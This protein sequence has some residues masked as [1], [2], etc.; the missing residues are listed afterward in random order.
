[1]VNK[2]HKDPSA[3]ADHDKLPQ[4]KITHSN[5]SLQYGKW[6]NLELVDD[7]KTDGNENAELDSQLL[8]A[9][10]LGMK[11]SLTEVNWSTHAESRTCEHVD[12]N[13]PQKEC[14]TGCITNDW[15]EPASDWNQWNEPAY[16]ERI[17]N[18]SSSLQSYSLNKITDDSDMAAE[19]PNRSKIHKCLGKSNYVSKV[20]KKGVKY[21][22]RK[23]PI[24]NQ[25]FNCCTE[26]FL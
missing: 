7:V 21:C 12:T 1:M 13:S 26:H 16:V 10:Y 3:K 6:L 19:K 25:H 20:S 24:K 15:L 14:L 4:V 17:I 23:K 9:D 22:N 11:Q 8:I 5:S 2:S 18:L